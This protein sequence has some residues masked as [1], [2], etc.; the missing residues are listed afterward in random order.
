[1]ALEKGRS[2]WMLSTEMRADR[3]LAYK[4]A[5]PAPGAVRLGLLLLVG[6]S[7]AACG[8]GGDAAAPVRAVHLI[9]LFSNELVSNS[10]AA[11][12]APAV[13][14]EFGFDED[15]EGLPEGWSAV[16]HVTGLTARRGKLLGRSTG[17]L[18]LVAYRWDAADK[19]GDFLRAVELT[20]TA[21]A[22]AIYISFHKDGNVDLE[23]LEAAPRV[24]IPLIPSIDVQTVRAHVPAPIMGSEI[25]QI[26]IQVGDSPGGGF[27]IQSLRLMFE[28]EYL[29]EYSTGV[30]WQG[31]EDIFHET[32][33]TRSPEIVSYT[34]T[35]PERPWL[36]LTLGTVVDGPVTFEITATPTRS[37]GE[38]NRIVR[39][40]TLTSP[41]RWE[42]LRVDLASLAR[43]E[44]ELRLALT[45]PVDR[46]VG[47]WGSP[48][49][50]SRE[51]RVAAT[52]AASPLGDAPQGVILLL[53]DTLRR[54]HLDLY[55]HSRPT[56]PNLARM[57]EAGAVFEG[58]TAQATWTKVSVPSI[59][60]GLYPLTHTVHE[61][62]DRLPNSARTLA[63][64]Y[65]EAGYATAGF[66]SVMFTGKFSNMH[67]GYEQLH[68]FTSLDESMRSKTSRQ[69][70]DRLLPWLEAHRDVPFFVFLHVFDPHD[71]FEPN[72][73]Y[74]TMWADPALRDE[75]HR[76]EKRVQEVIQH[77]IL[78]RFIMPS[79]EELESVEIPPAEFVDY[80][81]AWYDG[82]IR[83]M[84]T[85]VGRLLER[86]EMLGLAD[87]TL[88]VMTSDHG[89]EFLEH[90]RT[91]HGHTVY[92]ELTNVP[93][94]FWSPGRIDPNI[95]RSEIVESIDIVPTLLEIS[96]LSVPESAQGRSLMPLLGGGGNWEKQPAFSEKAKTRHPFG[97][98]DPALGSY[99]AT[100]EEWKLVHN[101]HRR[102][103]MEEFELYN[104]QSDPLNL[105]NVAGDHPQIVQELAAEI[106]RW[107]DNAEAAALPSD[108]EASEHLDA[109]ELERLRNLGYIQ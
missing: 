83:E 57:A 102:P 84:D 28:E 43:E 55:G 61:F 3:N 13:R 23:S 78:K 80:N 87:K 52:P 26:V 33:V 72:R 60:T 103:G 11:P 65:R 105:N 2:E 12:A 53:V 39:R 38:R 41:D 108:D 47:L 74:N 30:S 56:A 94:I 86:L 81:K 5:A 93:L 99:A 46:A 18:P 21:M 49:V 37:G 48:A 70:V 100:T 64:I 17:D 9:D 14:T 79:R 1:M 22:P 40:R 89:E 35:L 32:L 92:G 66:S 106:A 54:D 16:Q 50:R 104:M 69:Y 95:R 88:V 91:F 68:E 8:P 42:P 76:R 101:V 15:A 82:S 4:P 27:Q 25:E 36:D 10:P 85:Q 107:R 71:P 44:V 96:G 24:R 77:P 73:P 75:H 97:T 63:E 20:A 45:A 34:L 98:L 62:D 7:L 51:G 67:Q 59:V 58:A 29:G 6:V 19:P 109:G 31:L 90:G